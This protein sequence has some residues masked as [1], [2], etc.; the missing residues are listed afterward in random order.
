MEEDAKKKTCIRGGREDPIL[1][2]I[3]THDGLG[4]CMFMGWI[5]HMDLKNPPMMVMK[6]DIIMACISYIYI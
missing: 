3:L 6:K 1:S 4:I 2:R 5:R